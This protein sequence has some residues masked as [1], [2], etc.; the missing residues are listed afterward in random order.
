V[1]FLKCQNYFNITDTWSGGYN[2]HLTI[3][4]PSPD[5]LSG[6]DSIPSSSQTKK[7]K[8]VVFTASLLDVQHLRDS[9]K[10]DWLVHLLC[11]WARHLTGYLYLWIFGLTDSSICQL[12]CSS[13]G[14]APG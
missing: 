7:L 8:N 6:F 14:R 9:V 10:I 11:P 12:R 4:K 2:V 5:F 13:V 1:L 3:G